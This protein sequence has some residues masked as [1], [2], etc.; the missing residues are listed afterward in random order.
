MLQPSSITLALTWRH[1]ARCRPCAH[2][3]HAHL[4]ADKILEGFSQYAQLTRCVR[5]LFP[6]SIS[7]TLQVTGSMVC[8]SGPSLWKQLKSAVR[9]A[10]KGSKPHSI[11]RLSK[12]A[13][14]AAGHGTALESSRG[15]EMGS[16]QGCLKLRW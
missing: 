11:S 4:Y 2:C 10:F 13:A 1:I 16:F 15:H 6:L 14:V 8:I 12:V 5:V 7:C 3:E 9:K